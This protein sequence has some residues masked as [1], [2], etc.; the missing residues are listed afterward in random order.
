MLEQSGPPLDCRTS[1]ECWN[2]FTDVAASVGPI[3]AFRRA[4]FRREDRNA[5]SIY[6]ELF[7]GN[8]LPTMTPPGVPYEP[9]WARR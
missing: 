1:L 3:E 7:A 8:N 2:L 6:D 4:A 5:S 9:T